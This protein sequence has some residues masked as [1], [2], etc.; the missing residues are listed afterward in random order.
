MDGTDGGFP[1]AAPI[2]TAPGTFFGTTMLGGSNYGV[3]Y[4]YT[5]AQMSVVYSFR[6]ANDGARPGGIVEY[7]DGL[8]YGVATEGGPQ[9]VGTVYK[10]T[11]D[12]ALTPLLAFNGETDGGSP[13][14]LT[15]GS[16]GNFYGVTSG[17]YGA[18]SDD[19]T[20]YEL[21]PSG[22][23]TQL[24]SFPR[25]S[26]GY[27]F[28]PFVQGSDGNFYGTTQGGG[29][30]GDGAVYKLVPKA[31]LAAP[32]Q[33]SFNESSVA[34]GSPVTLTWKSLNSFSLTMQQCYAFVQGGASG[35]GTW[36]GKQ[37]GTYNSGTKQFSGSAGITP[38]AAGTYTYA[39]TCGGVES[40]FATLTVTAATK[41]NTATTVTATPNPLYIGQTVSVTAT[42]TK[43]SGSGAPTGSVGFYADGTLLATVGLNKSGIA[44]FTA[45]SAPYGAGT[46]SLVAKYS[47]DSLDNA[48]TSTAENVVLK[49]P[50]ITTT[51]LTVSPS[52][53]TPPADVTLTATV[54]S[55]GGM[56]SGS[57]TFY[58]DGE[59]LATVNVNGSGVATLKA[60][61]SG[62][63]AGTYS[64]TAKYNGATAFKD[65]TSTAS[66]VTVK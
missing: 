10:T 2:E 39:L 66:T 3:L 25:G 31:A 57:V 15:V 23:Y 52:T 27:P 33:L 55:G 5:G 28:G 36:T 16:D 20:M 26:T 65:S 60:S 53:V 7:S 62:V 63:A 61:S 49:A 47:G 43:N 41:V 4:E 29:T 42:V 11:L 1:T 64:V 17:Y 22:T 34:A 37:A 21:T 50:A 38:T 32:V 14:A 40:G 19:G 45:S 13:W 35:A 6:D 9:G 18:A 24:Y 58:A 44:S 48:S 30:D 8:L 56:P 59:A 46:Y 54:S 12:G 51:A